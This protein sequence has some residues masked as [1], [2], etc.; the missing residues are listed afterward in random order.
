MEKEAVLNKVKA[1]IEKAKREGIERP[2]N[3]HLASGGNDSLRKVIH[4]KEQADAFMRK[5][6]A[7]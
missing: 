1:L 4:T 6:E 2:A 3:I 5:L 7:L